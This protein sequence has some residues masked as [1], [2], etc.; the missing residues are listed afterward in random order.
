MECNDFRLCSAWDGREAVKLFKKK[1]DTGVA[2]LDY[3]RDSIERSSL[4]SWF[5]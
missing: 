2:E 3:F 4:P 5:A 1:K